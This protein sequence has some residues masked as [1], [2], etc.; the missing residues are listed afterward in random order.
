MPRPLPLVAAFA[1]CLAGPALAIGPED[2][3]PPAPTRTTTECPA[4]QVWD[5]ETEACTAIEQ[6][7]LPEDILR[8]TAR[9]LAYAG[10]S[11]DALELLQRSGAPEASEVLTLTAFAHGRAGRI[12][13]ALP[14]YDRALAADPGNLLARAYMG[15]A[16]IAAGRSEDAGMQLAEIR[17]RGGAGSWPDRALSRGLAAGAPVGY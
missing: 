3:S 17:A 5:A 11:D 8:R 6:S 9:E 13:T 12:D 15:L 2:D 7:R 16:L 1:F 10:R 14:I 4:G